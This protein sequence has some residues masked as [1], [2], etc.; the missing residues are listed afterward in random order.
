MGHHVHSQK[1]KNWTPGEVAFSPNLFFLSD[2]VTRILQL[3]VF[4]RSS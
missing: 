3:R 1:A 4:R 2:A